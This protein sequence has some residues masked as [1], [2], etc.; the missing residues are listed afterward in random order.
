[1]RDLHARRYVLQARIT[2]SGTEGMMKKGFLVLLGA[3]LLPAAA[4]AQ[5]STDFPGTIP[6]N[7]RFRF[8]GIYANWK[9]DVTFSTADNPGEEIDFA[10]LMDKPHKFTF[11][12]EGFWNFAGRSFLDFGYISFGTKNEQTITRDIH[13]G[14]VTFVAGA[15]VSTETFSRFAYAAYR[16]GIVKTPS[17]QLGL[18]LGL[19]YATL[20]AN[21]TASA[22][23][24]GPGGTPVV[25]TVAKEAEIQAPIPLLGIEAEGQIA[26]KLSGGIR[27]R[28]FGA[29][30]SPYSGNAEE[31]LGHVDYFIIQN[32]GIGGAYEWTHLSMKK[33]QDTKTIQFNYHY[34]G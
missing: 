28:A 13:F 23:V 21:M 24:L 31:V 26:E 32:F 3:V 1:M 10:K 2:V 6:D 5:S 19:S 27:F 16:Y 14:G 9:S 33:E 7:I 11:R 22:G 20:R 4:L 29:T 15:D 25:G 8:G 12:G 18:S 34:N 17:F 30:I